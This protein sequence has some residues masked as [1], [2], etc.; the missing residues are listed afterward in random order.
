MRNQVLL[1]VVDLI[2]RARISPYGENAHGRNSHYTPC[3]PRQVR[4]NQIFRFDL[5]Q[6]GYVNYYG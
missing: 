3:L 2:V 1:P 4:D 6:K 5:W